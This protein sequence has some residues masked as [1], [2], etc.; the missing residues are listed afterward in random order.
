MSVAMSAD[1]MLTHSALASLTVFS[2]K[3]QYVAIT[4]MLPLLICCHVVDRVQLEAA[5]YSYGAK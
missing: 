5:G 4:N 1:A 3:L 2:W